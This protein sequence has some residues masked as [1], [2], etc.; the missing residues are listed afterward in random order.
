MIQT[1]ALAPQAR[2]LLSCLGALPIVLV[3]GVAAASGFMTARFGGEHGHVVTD[4]PTAL[5]YNPAGLAESKGTNIWIEYQLALRAVGY[6]HA[7]RPACTGDNHPCDVPEPPG[8]R[9]AN[10]DQA[11]LFNTPGAPMI[12]ASTKIG[13]L[14]I[15]AGFFIPFG[16]REVWS[17]NERFT[18]NAPFPGIVDG[19][20]R[21]YAIEGEIISMYFSLGVAYKI[22]QIGLS[23]GAA[24]NLIHSNIKTIRART[25]PPSND[26]TLEGRS[27]L[28]VKG[29]QG[30]FGVGA[31]FEAIKEQLW[32]GLSYQARPN[33]SGGMTLKGELTAT[34][35]GDPQE[36]ALHQDYPDVI[37]LGARWKPTP[38]IEVRL[39]GEWQRWSAFKDQC[40]SAVINGATKPC[41]VSQ[42][43]IPD[44]DGNGPREGRLD[45]ADLTREGIVQ[46]LPRRWHDGFGIRAGGSYWVHPKVELFT[47]LGYDGSAIPSEHLEPVLMS[48]PRVSVALGGRVD[49]AKFLRIGLSYTHLFGIPQ[50]TS[51]ESL[52]DT[53]DLASR[54][55]DAG[56]RY[57]ETIGVFNLNTQ[58]MF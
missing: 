24:A 55:P 20:Q 52:N 17:K 29:F 47:G 18:N 25:L 28:D 16:G 9:G 13:N 35:V 38:K 57:T 3:P 6:K 21:W 53:F 10:T 54:G 19:A 56:G 43:P 31:M 58:L 41:E 49:V 27:L 7:A 39:F 51:G 1:R 45:G 48:I 32:F 50:D 42:E 5:Y 37:R 26:I 36:V 11:S 12:G 46:N 34:Q 30:S 8:A 2:T 15:G 22:P 40:V 44:P 14:A 4:N 23:I 33:V